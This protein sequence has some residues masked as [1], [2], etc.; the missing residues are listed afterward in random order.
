MADLFETAN[1][2]KDIALLI[3]VDDG[4][5]QS[6]SSVD[7]LERLA[8]TAGIYTAGKLF[9]KKDAPDKAT[10]LGIGKIEEAA[11]FCKA[12]DV[13]IV[14]ADDELKGSQV[15]ELEDILDL[16]VIDRTTLILDIFASRAKT[17][18]GKLQVELAQYKYRLPRLT[19][20]GTALSRLGGGIGTRGPGET[21]LETDRRHIKR[22]ISAIEKELDEVSA[23]RA[24]TRNRRK[25]ENIPTVALVGYT[26]AGKSSLMN[27]LCN[28]AEVYVQDQLFA[29]LDATVRKIDDPDNS[30]VLLIDTVGFI[31]KLPHDL[32]NAFKSTLEESSNADLLLIVVDSCDNEASEQIDVVYSILKQ[33][34]AMNKP[35]FIIFNKSDK[36]GDLSVEQQ[37]RREVI[38]GS[39]QNA[40]T[41]IYEVSAVT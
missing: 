25:K 39:I 1:K 6:E 38:M 33:L 5:G 13:N 30:E 27:A 18:E 24:L 17:L 26:N 19:G 15:R 28:N 7:E 23:R 21:K 34:D 9:Q 8:E 10:Y 41:P 4:S 35:S 31:R 14:I 11:E 40:G 32:V 36:V 29:T 20:Y 16:R 37:Y 12:N 22:K 2:D 3:A